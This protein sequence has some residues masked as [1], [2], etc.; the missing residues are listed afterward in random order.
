LQ[1]KGRGAVVVNESEEVEVGK[2]EGGIHRLIL[3]TN[4]TER[5]PRGWGIK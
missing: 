1:E 4:V 5:P 2:K 3:G